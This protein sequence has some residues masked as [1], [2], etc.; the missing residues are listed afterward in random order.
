MTNIRYL[1]TKLMIKC[2]FTTTDEEIAKCNSLGTV[3]YNLEFFYKDLFSGN[4]QHTFPVLKYL[5][6]KNKDWQWFDLV[7]YDNTFNWD[8]VIVTFE[9]EFYSYPSPL[10]HPRSI[11]ID[12]GMVTFGEVWDWS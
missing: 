6:E 10:S 3:F 2:L 5:N 12:E 11:N 1:P 4:I 7:Y 8:Y 9:Q